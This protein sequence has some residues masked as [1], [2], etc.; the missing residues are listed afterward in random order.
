MTAG[1]AHIRHQRVADNL[2]KMGPLEPSHWLV[3][4]AVDCPC[5]EL[6]FMDGDYVTLVPLGPGDDP[7]ERKL[8]RERRAFDAVGIT[9]HWACATGE[10]GPQG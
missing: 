8:A 7:D 9:V 4:R 3:L 6:P 1:L 2:H 10:E 5:C